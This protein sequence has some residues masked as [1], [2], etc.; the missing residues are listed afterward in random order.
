MPVNTE[1]QAYADMKKRWETIDDVCDGATKIKKKGEAYLPKPNVTEDQTQNDK[2]YEAYLNRA[3]FY[4][5]SKDT[6]NKMV[7]VVF[8]EDPTFE[9]DGMDFLKYD[10]D[11]TG[12]S[13]YQV[14]QSGL[15]GQLKH[16]RGGFLVDYPVTDGNVSVQQAESMGIRPTIV[17]Y[18]SLSIL[19]WRLKRV[20]SVYKPDLIVLHEK[21]T[22]QDPDDEF[23]QKEVNSYRVLRLDENNQ[24]YVQ[25]YTDETGT[26]TGGEVYYPKNSLGQGWSE[27]TFIP[28]GS[29]AND[30]KIDPIPLEPIVTMNLAH[31]QNSASYEEMVFICGQAQ[32]VINELDTDWR[33]WLQKNG[34]RLGSKNPLMLPKGS[35]FDYKQVTE[36][37]LAK[38]AMEA[39]EKYMQ[40]QGA[41]ITE[42]N[43]SLKTAT[44][45]NNEKLSQYSVLSLCVANLNEAMEYCL[46]WSAEFF[47]SGKNAKFVIK[48]DFAKGK[49]DLDA[50]KF[51]W[52]MVLAN[53]LS[54]ETFH[55]LLTTG[56]VPEISFEDE[57]TR[58]ES[59]SVN[60]PMVV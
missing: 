57:Q 39:K 44:Q 55:E 14:A 18:D 22:K 37:T 23:S 48:Q 36:S 32:P 16:A 3:V 6:L 29:L 4:E 24:Y 25:I 50:L 45:S 19:N 13:I 5:I 53:R 56:K 38:Q 49:I 42:Q 26:L 15:Q 47:G 34:I 58:I 33:D 41:K 12:K 11:G 20:G 46:K 9:P 31:Y 28:L 8:A 35:T 52:E 30:W 10:A 1:H 54:M 43:E 2:Y 51:Y 21:S 17:F 59:E 40:S 60:R 27:I 7:G